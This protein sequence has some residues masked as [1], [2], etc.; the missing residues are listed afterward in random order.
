MPARYD[1]IVAGLGAMGSAACFHLARAGQRVLGLDRFTPPHTLGSSHG[2][3]RIIREAYFEDPL[4]VPLVQRAYTLWEELARATQTELFIQTGGLMISTPEATVFPGARQSAEQ[5]RLAHE[6]LTGPQV[7]ARFPVLQ[8]TDAMSAVWEPRAGILFPER[9][10]AAHLAQAGAAGADLRYEEPVTRW[11]PDGAGIRV[12]TRQSSY[13]ADQLILAAGPW[14]PSLL[15]ELNLPLRIERQVQFW[16]EPVHRR[17]GFSPKNCPIHLWQFD[18][19]R[20]FY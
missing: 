18:G 4:Y 8:P 13:L 14:M 11:E 9:C 10:V 17:D 6:I 20:F 2:Q 12:A 7:R 19:R 1:V 16:F 5:H 15:T 3:T